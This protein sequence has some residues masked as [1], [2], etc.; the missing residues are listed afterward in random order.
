MSSGF[1][2]GACA[3]TSVAA[4][5]NEGSRVAA[6]RFMRSSGPCLCRDRL[7]D[8]RE[9]GRIHEHRLRLLDDL[10]VLFGFRLGFHP[11]RIG[12]EGGPVLLGVVAARVG[13]E[14][15]QGG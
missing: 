11:F 13:G 9:V 12:L 3:E 10:A 2:P 14:V 5:T 15:G 6:T 1:V 4:K 7:L 8:L